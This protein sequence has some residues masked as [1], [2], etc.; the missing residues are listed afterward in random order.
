MHLFFVNIRCDG[1]ERLSRVV[2]TAAQYS[3]GPTIR[4][5]PSNIFC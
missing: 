2:S 1:T 5:R 3:G 4:L